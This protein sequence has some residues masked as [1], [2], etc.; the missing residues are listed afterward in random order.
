MTKNAKKELLQAVRARYLKAN[1][2]G[3]ERILD[4]F[5]ASTGY[6]RKYAIKLLNHGPK[7]IGIQKKGRPEALPG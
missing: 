1:K 2:A 6:H 3:K 4:E 5:V 7:P